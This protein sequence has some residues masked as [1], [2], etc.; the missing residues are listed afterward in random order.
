[1]AM[2]NPR[3]AVAGD[4]HFFVGGDDHDFDFGFRCRDNA[5]LSTNHFVGFFVNDD[6]K[7]ILN[8]IQNGFAEN[9]GIFADSSGE[10]DQIDPRRQALRR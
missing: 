1:M 8:I 9:R 5:L 3:I 6:A 2:N 10:D 4:H 7:G